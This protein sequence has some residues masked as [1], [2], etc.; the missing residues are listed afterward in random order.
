MRRCCPGDNAF[1]CF[2]SSYS[3]HDASD[4]GIAMTGLPRLSIT[5][6]VAAP[7]KLTF[8]DMAAI[9]AE[10]QISDVSRIDPK[11]AGDAVRLAGLLKLAGAKPAARYLGLHS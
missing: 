2:R 6:E 4:W 10:F 11:R 7:K 5:G 3:S 9:P 8:D 1:F